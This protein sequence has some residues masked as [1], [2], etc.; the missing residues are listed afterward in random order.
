VTA[1]AWCGDQ[2]NLNTGDWRDEFIE[3]EDVMDQ[4]MRG[5]WLLIL[6]DVK[7]E[8]RLLIGMAERPT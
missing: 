6:H 5:Q 7:A 1:K 8:F 2:A 4:H 3:V